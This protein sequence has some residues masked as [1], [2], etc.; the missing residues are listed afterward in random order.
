MMKDDVQK[1]EAGDYSTNLQ[2][3]SIVIHQGISYADAKEIALD[4][5]KANFLQLAQDA[6]SLAINRAE[7]LTDDFL[8]RL[9]ERAPETIGSMRDPAMQMAIF[10]AQRE[11]AKSGDMDLEDL[12][13][14]ILVE[15]PRRT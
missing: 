9:K 3:K 4:V 8:A 6:A 7:Q 13:I 11:Y 15:R 12:L 2:G 1:Q 5:Y 14:D 10:T